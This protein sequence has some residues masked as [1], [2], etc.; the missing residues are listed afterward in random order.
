MPVGQAV[1]QFSKN[2]NT[3][4]T[5]NANDKIMCAYLK[6]L[7]SSWKSNLFKRT[8]A[9]SCEEHNG[10]MAKIQYMGISVLTEAKFYA[11]PVVIKFD[12]KLCTCIISFCFWAFSTM[13]EFIWKSW[14]QAWHD[15]N[16]FSTRKW[17]LQIDATVKWQWN[18]LPNIYKHNIFCNPL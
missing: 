8:T 14:L 2:P 5:N 16:W 9:S 6:W 3:L 1:K 15:E 7:N 12:M 17:R 11:L 10:K 13:E 18:E 4:F